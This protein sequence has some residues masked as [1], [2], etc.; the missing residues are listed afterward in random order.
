MI[1]VNGG[2]DLHTADM[3]LLLPTTLPS[4]YKSLV[5]IGHIVTE[6]RTFCVNGDLDLHFQD[7][8]LQELDSQAHCDH[9]G[10]NMMKIG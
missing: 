8:M 10:E 2:L 3:N 7:H 1:V 5:Q 6:I 9:F 4:F